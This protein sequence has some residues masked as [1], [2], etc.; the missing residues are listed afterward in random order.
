MVVVL[1]TSI[2]FG[3]NPVANP[4]TVGLVVGGL[5]SSVLGQVIGGFK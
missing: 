5:S 3:K 2:L 4:K 1:T